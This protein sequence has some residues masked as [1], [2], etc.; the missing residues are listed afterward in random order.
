VS[1]AIASFL[2]SRQTADGGLRLLTPVRVTR[3]RLVAAADLLLE[4]TAGTLA[5]DGL[6]PPS[7]YK[8]PLAQVR[9][10]S[11]KC[12]SADALDGGIALPASLTAP[13]AASA[14]VLT[15]VARNVTAGLPPSETALAR[16]TLDE[17]EAVQRSLALLD[18][19]LDRATEGDRRAAAAAPEAMERALEVS[20]GFQGLV[21]RALF[22]EFGGG[23][24]KEG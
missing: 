1:A 8:A 23:E 17:A 6:P 4:A 7:A 5:R 2:R 19:L 10:A 14:C 11:L 13:G 24:K 20:R 12:F 22:E 21:E 16:A 9:A 15:A 3:E 18:D